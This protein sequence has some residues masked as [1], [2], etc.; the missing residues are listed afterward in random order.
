MFI[1]IILGAIISYV[2]ILG[3]YFRIYYTLIHE[4]GHALMTILTKGQ[5][6]HIHLNANESGHAMAGV[7]GRFQTFLVAIVGYPTPLVITII[8]LYFIEEGKFTEIL[9]GL[10]I[11]AAISL[12]LWVRN[13]FGVVW[14][15]LFL[16]TSIMIYI[17]GSDLFIAVYVKVFTGILY[18]TSFTNTLNIFRV[19]LNRPMESGDAKL[20][21]Q[22]TGLPVIV[23][24]V[25]FLGT[26]IGMIFFTLPM[27]F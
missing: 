7:R 8:L 20:L 24:G 5:L 22:V 18:V 12:L 2:P 3:K 1:F 17:Q 9:L 14:V 10:I 16:F 15:V 11:T 13:A 26:G 23:W 6:H 21:Q 27:I 19:S 25:L 4:L